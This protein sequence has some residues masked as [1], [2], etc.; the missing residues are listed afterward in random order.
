MAL[1]PQCSFSSRSPSDVDA[2][3]AS[4]HRDPHVLE[5]EAAPPPSAISNMPAFN[6]PLPHFSESNPSA[7]VNGLPPQI[8]S[9]F[10]LAQSLAS[11][12][13]MAFPN[14]S[15]PLTNAPNHS[16]ALNISNDTTQPVRIT[17]PPESRQCSSRSLETSNVAGRRDSRR[18]YK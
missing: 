14:M 15:L 2:H 6:L 11:S 12:M 18:R 4:V 16:N 13:P 8:S 5:T 3:M 10:S 17:D 1:C 9:L 7:P